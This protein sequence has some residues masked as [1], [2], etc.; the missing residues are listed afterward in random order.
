VFR[1][2]D[3]VLLDVTVFLLIFLS[4]FVT[5]ILALLS[6]SFR[7]SGVE[8]NAPIEEIGASDNI[9]HHGETFCQYNA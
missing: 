8:Q 1:N 2:L 9:I 6:L 7:Q 5:S 4:L 3:G